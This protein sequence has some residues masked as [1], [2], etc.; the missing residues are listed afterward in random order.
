MTPPTGNDVAV[1]GGTRHAVEGS[2]TPTI[3]PPSGTD[4]AVLG[5]TRHSVQGAGTPT[6]SGP[7]GN[8]VVVSGGTR[9]AVQ[10]A[11][12]PSLTPPGGNDISVSGGTRHAIQGSGVPSLTPPGGNDVAVSGGTRH[13]IQGAGTPSVTL[14][15]GTDVAVSGGVR[16][17]VRG[18]GVLQLTS[19]VAEPMPTTQL[20]QLDASP[21]LLPAQWGDAANLRGLVDIW[22][23]VITE[24]VLNPVKSLRS[25]ARLE[26]A[27]GYWLDQVGL[28]L[29]VPRPWVDVPNMGAFGLDDAGVGFDQGRLRQAVGLQ[30]KTPIGDELYRRLLQARCWTLIGIGNSA[31][32]EAAVAEVDPFASVRDNLDMSFKIVTAQALRDRIGGERGVPAAPGGRPAGRR[33]RRS[34]RPRRCGRG[35]R[36]GAHEQLTCHATPMH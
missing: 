25:M 31:Y 32:M 3:T 33:G 14:L 30:P 36:S 10:G 34:V 4:V 1:S 11:G 29:G 16:H 6:V 24:E 21:N 27:T 22:L 9:H 13:G 20:E 5:G 19:T 26:E 35:I 8:D 23:E 2:G 18:A 17:A 12:V 7:G 28:R 15:S